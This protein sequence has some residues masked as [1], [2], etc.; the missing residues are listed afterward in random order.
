M[1]ILTIAYCRIQRLF[2]F[3]R[4]SWNRQFK[5]GRWK[6][7]KHCPILIQQVAEL[8]SGGQILEFGCGE[9][10]VPHMLPHGSFSEY[11]GYDISDVAIELAKGKA[12]AAGLTNCFFEQADMAE[13]QGHYEASVILVEESL[14]YLSPKKAKSFLQRCCDNLAPYG[15]ILVVVHSATK[16]AKTLEI[17]REV[18]HELDSKQTPRTY[19]TLCP[20]GA[21][22]VFTSSRAE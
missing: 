19:L 6:R 15:A 8:C 16:H 1:N 18:C 9:G 2:G 13:W 21:V 4:Q 3:K 10:D 5:A 14:Y 20:K 12:Q 17:C 11:R 22:T 7:T